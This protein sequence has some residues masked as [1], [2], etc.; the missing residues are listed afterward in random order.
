MLTW[1]FGDD[2][3]TVTGLDVSHTHQRAG[4]FRPHVAL[5]Y[6]QARCG[7]NL[8]LPPVEVLDMFIPNAFTPNAD[9]LN[10]F[11]EPCLSGCP[12]RLRVFSRWGQLA[13]ESAAY[14]NNW[15]GIGRAPGIYYY[16]LTPP[17]GA[18]PIKGWVELLR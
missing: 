4:T 17:D 14:H 18:A 2:S 12:A 7:Q 8:H 10:N 15:G 3:T 6:N 5:H 9:Y 1:N 16:L 13:F 11:F